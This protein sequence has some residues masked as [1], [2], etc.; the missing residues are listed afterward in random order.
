M[1]NEKESAQWF[2]SLL[3]PKVFQTFRI[4]I[5]PSKLIIAFLAVA[6]ICV[7]GWLMDFN[8]TV[9]TTPDTQGQ[10]TEL[11]IYVT[12]PDQLESYVKDA[13]EDG[14]R[15]GVFSTLWRFAAARFHGALFSLFRFNI[16]GV[17]GN[18]I[19]CFKALVWAI[20]YHYIYSIIFFVIML[21]VISI[22]GGAIC[23]IAA[24]QFARDEKPGLTETLRFSLKKFSS[25]FAAPLA[26]AGI[27]IFI[28]FFIF[29]LGLVGNIP[30]AGKPIM[31]VFMVLALIAG[32]LITV[33]LIGAVAGLNLMFPA[34]AYDDADCFDAISRAFSYV[35]AKPWRMGFYT[36]IAAVYGAACY[37]FV[38][39]F[40]FLLLWVTYLAL[41]LGILG[42]NSK[43]TGLWRDKPAFMDLI[44]PPNWAALS[45]LESLG[46]FL[47][48]LLLLAVIVLIVAFLVSFYFSANTIIYALMRKAVDNT[49]LQD[50]YTPI[51][52][53]K[54]EPAE[55]EP[56]ETPPE[57]KSETQP[58]SKPEEQPPSESETKSDSS[59][60][61]Q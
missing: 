27:I 56:K 33:V 35:F 53:T 48:Y 11:H 36:A 44:V 28:G 23:R 61:G 4:A 31:V 50:V 37:M 2:D 39:F 5:Q 38:R 45:S 26:P 34:V 54:S 59:S 3:F 12:T 40:A 42:D 24:L 6:V 20:K 10:E 47:V 17:A 25:F 15:I 16:Q 22:A 1:A 9:V 58:E 14:E 8:K 46:A 7:A 43:L 29:L 21:A 52:E 19:D 51:E 32:G 30:W 13:K 55:P 60:S 41:Q 49:A 18:T 57:S